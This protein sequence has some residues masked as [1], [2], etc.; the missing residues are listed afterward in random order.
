MACESCR[1]AAPGIFAAATAGMV[2][3]T[4][5]VDKSP[6]SEAAGPGSPWAA[7]PVRGGLSCGTESRGESTPVQG[8]VRGAGNIPNLSTTPA[9][10]DSLVVPAGALCGAGSCDAGDCIRGI[11]G[12]FGGVAATVEN[13][14]AGSS[15]RDRRALLSWDGTAED[16][17]VSRGRTRDEPSDRGLRTISGMVES[18][19][20]RRS[21]ERMASLRIRAPL[22]GFVMR[23]VGC[24]LR[25]G[26][27]NC[28]E[29]SV[30][31]ADSMSVCGAKGRRTAGAGPAGST[32]WISTRL[33]TLL[34]TGW[35]MAGA[36]MRVVAG[37]S[38]ASGMAG[39]PWPGRTPGKRLGTACVS[40]GLSV[41]VSESAAFE[42]ATGDGSGIGGCGH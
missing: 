28:H 1:S 13:E 22:A 38:N 40:C 24:E 4:G 12:P 21:V 3:R 8:T 10:Q 39:S 41:T 30:V 18:V 15:A 6:F 34:V 23:G 35:G 17:P 20:A 19:S 27:W 32:D 42:S 7:R 14:S 16:P 37:V 36:G 9:A 11:A 31:W 26:L 25:P 2:I 29:L 33:C 5:A